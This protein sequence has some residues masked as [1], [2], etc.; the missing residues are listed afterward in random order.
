[1]STYRFF[2][3]VGLGDSAVSIHFKALANELVSRGHQVILLPWG[4]GSQKQVPDSNPAIIPWPSPRPTHLADAVFLRQL[5]KQ[6]EPHC[7]IGLF[8]AVNVMTAVGWLSRVPC[9]VAWYRTL[10]YQILQ[11]WNSATW[12]HKFLTIRKKWVY[13][14]CTHV[15]GN[16]Q[17]TVD[18]IIKTFGVHQ[19]KSMMFYNS[20]PAPISGN[21]KPFTKKAGLVVCAGRFHPSKGQDVLL[22]AAAMAREHTPNIKVSFLGQG[23]LQNEY[24]QLAKSLGIVDICEFLGHVSHEDVLHHMGQASVT[25]VPSRAEAFG[26]VALESMAVGTPVIASRVG[27]LAE[28]VRDELDGFLIPPDNPEILADRLCIILN[29]S[30][31]RNQMGQQARGRFLETFEQ[32]RA[33]QTQADWFEEIVAASQQK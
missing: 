33:V 25:V 23:P 2:I 32:K 20:L 6:H 7:L 30:S 28:I 17:A 24:E 18:D 4:K 22:K 19:Q 27:G 3:G 1:M 21:N 9:R 5:I 31:L 11:D 8:G 16:S 26:F 12:R 13:R 14:I 10:S 29:N 15:I